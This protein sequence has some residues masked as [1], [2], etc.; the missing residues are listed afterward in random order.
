MSSNIL[1]AAA[2]FALFGPLHD[3][4]MRLPQPCGHSGS[5]QRRF[6]ADHERLGYLQQC[7]HQLIALRQNRALAILTCRRIKRNQRRTGLVYVDAYVDHLWVA[8]LSE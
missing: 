4:D 6:Y 2:I 7:R 3:W 5:K 8:S 1:R